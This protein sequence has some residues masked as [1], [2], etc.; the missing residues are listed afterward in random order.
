MQT[1]TSKQLRATARTIEA[2]C[3]RIESA[4]HS[5]THKES[6]DLLYEESRRLVALARL[7]EA[8]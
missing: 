8:L 3:Q 4:R 1:N 2:Q 6:I 7:L 5:D